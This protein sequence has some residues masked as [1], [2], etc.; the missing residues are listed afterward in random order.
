MPNH[1]F[2]TE[3]EENHSR[4]RIALG[5]NLNIHPQKIQ[6]IQETGHWLPQECHGNLIPGIFRVT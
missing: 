1:T 5:N 4:K 6:S 2:Y 3:L